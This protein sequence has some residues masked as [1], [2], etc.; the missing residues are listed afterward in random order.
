M[1]RL[2]KALLGYERK[3]LHFIKLSELSEEERKINE[4][5]FYHLGEDGTKYSDNRYPINTQ[6]HYILNA[7]LDKYEKVGFNE[8]MS[9]FFK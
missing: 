8:F 2:E 5:E 6:E 1:S 4:R 7:V 9:R 3:N